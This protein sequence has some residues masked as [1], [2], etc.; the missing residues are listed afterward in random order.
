MIVSG[1]IDPRPSFHNAAR[2]FGPWIALTPI[3]S[4]QLQRP[5]APKALRK[6]VK[7]RAMVGVK[8]IAHKK[9]HVNHRPTLAEQNHRMFVR[10]HRPAIGS[11]TS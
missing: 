10:D 7:K 9:L 8:S 6:D 3:L 2:S 4:S 11:H 5:K 1:L